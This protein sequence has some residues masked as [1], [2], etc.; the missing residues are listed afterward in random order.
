MN[1]STHAPA[2][3]RSW[4]AATGAGMTNGSAPANAT[5]GRTPSRCP[6]AVTSQHGHDD[7][8]QD[9]RH[10]HDGDRRPGKPE[11]RRDDPRLDAEDVVEAVV[12]ERE[13]LEGAEAPRHQAD[14][15]LI[16]IEVEPFV[17]G[18][19]D[20]AHQDQ[21]GGGRD[22]QELLPAEA[23]R[24]ACDLHGRVSIQQPRN[25]VSAL[26]RSNSAGLAPCAAVTRSCQRPRT[27]K[28]GQ[29]RHSFFAGSE[30]EVLPPAVAFE[31][32]DVRRPAGFA[33]AAARVSR[34]R[35][36]MTK[37]A[38]RPPSTHVP[39]GSM[40]AWPPTRNTT[41]GP[42]RATCFGKLGRRPLRSIPAMLTGRTSRRPVAAVT[43]SAAHR[44]GEANSRRHAAGEASSGPTDHFHC[45]PNS[46]STVTVTG[47]ARGRR[48][49][50]RRGKR[51]PAD[52]TS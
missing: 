24:S 20:A 1:G 32:H 6:I 31:R 3:S 46:P 37:S 16:G 50:P 11:E 22:H 19:N 15:G 8:E 52:E 30:D 47:P 7:V 2:V 18:R 25:R 29:R 49:R 35:P 40:N 17:D 38:D 23:V 34:H 12:E 28:K 45:G 48:P 43:A 36:L 33:P 51:Q 21:D 9:E 14:D 44:H 27:R 13:T 42:Y 41:A 26:P 4:L 5:S 10:A 39:P